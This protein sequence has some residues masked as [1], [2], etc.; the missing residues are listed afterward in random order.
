MSDFRIEKDTMGEVRVP[1]QAY[2]GAQTQR[3]VENFPVSGIRFP[4]RFIQA[5][6]LIKWAAAGVNE[7]LGLLESRIADA[8]REAA[9]EVV[10]GRLDKEFVID[11]FQTG[12]GTSTNMN[13][14]EVIANRAV[15][16][17]G[18]DRGSKEIHP[19][20]HV[21]MCQSSNDVIPSAIRL[22]AVLGVSEDLIPALERLQAALAA[23]AVEFD[24]VVKV[25]RTHLMDATPVR[26]GQEFSGYA[27]QVERGVDRLRSALERLAELPLGGTAVGT[28]L[29]AHPEFASRALAV[30]AERTGHPLREAADH[31][32]A[33][34]AQDA[35]VEASG[36]LKTVAVSLM[37]IANDIRWMGSGPR[38]GIGELRLPSLQPGSSIMP[39]KVNPVITEVVR[40][41]SAQ[42]IGNDAAVT[43]GGA[44]GDFELNVM[45][46][47]MAHNL[48]QAVDL[49]TSAATLF[50][51]RCV[52]GLEADAE[53][54]RA[55]VEQSF[56]IITALV[57]KIGYEAA[58][59]IAK[60]A[61]ATGR[62]VREIAADRNVLSP[63]ELEDALDVRK[64]TEGGI[65]TLGGE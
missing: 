50:R 29:N 12:S 57:P 5:L 18:G 51:E 31:F 6:G 46:P 23:K 28:G 8:V 9:E 15:E 19:N 49:L 38:G 16:V 32:E 41:V 20:D 17:I 53:R 64:M 21:N 35:L 61:M 10:D 52:E 45:L 60:E 13:A 24:D 30:L 11:V 58:A 40:Q 26:L 2:Y 44:L 34:G 3:A 33:Q 37:K 63:E 55:L 25:G 42:V 48:L 27:M 7:E 22:A 36:A 65:L 62:G 1:R 59:D 47:V 4:R 56:P 39:G 54:A 43:V 14:N